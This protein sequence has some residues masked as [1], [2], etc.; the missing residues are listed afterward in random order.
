MKYTCPL[1]YFW[2][3]KSG[4]IDSRFWRMNDERAED[5]CRSFSYK[6][7]IRFFVSEKLSNEDSNPL[8]PSSLLLESIEIFD[9]VPSS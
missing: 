5:F 4:S 8:N 6:F 1:S 3:V 9:S 7:F 2:V